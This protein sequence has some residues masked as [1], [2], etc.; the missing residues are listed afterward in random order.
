MVTPGIGRKKRETPETMAELAGN[1][2]RFI[3]WETSL[4]QYLDKQLD[5]F[6]VA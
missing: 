3:R 1:C 2:A 6:F 5:Q 4:E